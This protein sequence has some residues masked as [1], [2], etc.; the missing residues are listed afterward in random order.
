[1]NT[2]QLC[3]KLLHCMPPERAHA[4]AI[5]A[6]KHGLVPPHKTPSHPSLAQDVLGMHL[7]N[8]IG[9]AAGFDKNAEALSGLQQQGFGFVEV[10]TVTPLS[11]PGNPKPRIFRLRQDQA[12]INRLGFNNQGLT[13]FANHLRKR[14]AVGIVGANLG[15]NKDSANATSDYVQGMRAV[16]ALVDYITIN[17][18]S[19]N[20]AGLRQLQEAQALFSLLESLMSAR[21]TL[22]GTIGRRVPLLL[23][24][25][26]DMSY[27]ER[28]AIAEVALY[29]NIDGIIVSNTTTSR[30][31]TLKSKHYVQSGGLSGAPLM[32]LSTRALREMYHLTEGKLPLIG[33]GGVASAADAYAKI[34]AGATLVQLY[35]AIIY[36]GFELVHQILEE[37]PV[38][39]ERDGFSS[40]SEAI[41]VDA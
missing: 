38:L 5:F 14:P 3:Q 41:G 16:Y 33:V 30:P 31:P 20:T 28:A 39:L 1:M 15:K 25:A 40:I 2:N 12:I 8:P 24:I 10:G 9:M 6:L 19:P 32:K 29:V 21:K 22:E 35:T 13:T 34:R 23:K 18:S 37:L 4:L 36:Q 17:V 27:E 11:Q 26:P 7:P